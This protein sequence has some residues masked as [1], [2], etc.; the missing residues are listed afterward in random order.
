MDQLALTKLIWHSVVIPL[1]EDG[2]FAEALQ[3]ELVA[4]D[5]PPGQTRDVDVYLIE[6]LRSPTVSSFDL[7]RRASGPVVSED[8]L[9][10]LLELLHQDCVSAPSSAALDDSGELAVEGP[11]DQDEGQRVFRDRLNPVLAQRV[12]P[13]EMRSNGQII[14][15]PASAMQP[16]VD[17]A[18]PE[19]VAPELRDPIEAA[20]NRFYRRD[21]TDVDRRDA[22]R[23]LSDF[24]E[25]QRSTIKAE[26]RSKDEDAL[27]QI[28]NQFAIRHH[29]EAQRGDYDKG[30]WQE[31][32]F[33]VFLAT[34][35][36]LIQVQDRDGTAD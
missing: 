19:S 26:M 20:I 32:I 25:H 17:E 14:E 33:H 36:A 34:A 7:L 8:V 12:P 29:Q 31:W 9:F 30:I 15:L 6:R 28:A 4:G 13:L 16:L 27:F 18:I 35:K 24:L 23:H 10:D 5:Q 22:L 3:P 2:Y 21:A 11:F 1:R